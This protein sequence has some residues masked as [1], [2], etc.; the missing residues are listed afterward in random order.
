MDYEKIIRIL[1]AHAAATAPTGDSTYSDYQVYLSFIRLAAE[2]RMPSSI[3]HQ[4]FAPH[5]HEAISRETRSAQV[6]L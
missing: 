5:D 4:P 3:S 2:D 6:G 1:A